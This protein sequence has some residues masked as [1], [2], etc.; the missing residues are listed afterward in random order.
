M[1]L[2]DNARTPHERR[3]H[4]AAK[5]GDVRELQN[6]LQKWRDD[7]SVSP[8]ESSDFHLAAGVAV[9]NNQPAALEYLLDQGSSADNTLARQAA[10]KNGNQCLDVLY[11][12][13][14][15]PESEPDGNAMPTIQMA[16]GNTEQLRW[17]L[18]HGANANVPCARTNDTPLSRASR[19]NS[20]QTVDLLLQHGAVLKDSNALHAAASG[21][22]P[23]EEVLAMMQHLIDL[24]ADINAL[25]VMHAKRS[26][27]NI[28][29]LGTALH[30]T[31]RAGKPARAQWLLEHGADGKIKNE[32][33]YSPLE[34]A[35]E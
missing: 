35:A 16:I 26:G 33:G 24:G 4:A 32:R 17:L 9:T 20:T 6:G 31:I 14:W 5:A 27:H 19:M 29:V 1:G 22:G 3:L 23:D 21:G 18:D 34:W 8:S 12:H 11:T 30:A 13:G 7:S 15:R 2:F 25:E 10:G 28:R